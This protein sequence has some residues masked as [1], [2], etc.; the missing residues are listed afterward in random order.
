MPEVPVYVLL[1]GDNAEGDNIGS[2][3]SPTYPQYVG[4]QTGFKIWN[5][6]G[7]AWETYVAGTNSAPESVTNAAHFGPEVSML[8]GLQALNPTQPN[9]YIVKVAVFGSSIASQPSTGNEWN[10]AAQELWTVMNTRVAAAMGNVPIGFTAKL[11]GIFWVH[12]EDDATV[13][14]CEAYE[15]L[16]GILIDR[17]RSTYNEPSIPF[18]IG[19]LHN[20]HPL[21]EPQKSYML[22]VRLAQEA[23]SRKNLNNTLVSTDTLSLKGDQT[24]F[25]VQGTINLGLALVAGLG[26]AGAA[27]SPGD[28]PGAGA[29]PLFILLGDDNAYGHAPLADLPSYLTGT[30]TG[31]K[32]WSPTAGAFQDLVV[33]TN[34][35]SAASSFGPEASLGHALRDMADE[36]IYLVKLGS[37]GSTLAPK[38]GSTNDWCPPSQEIYADLLS[39]LDA[40][41][42]EL[43]TLSIEPRLD[44]IFIV[45][46]QNDALEDTTSSLYEGYLKA[47]VQHLRNDAALRDLVADSTKLPVVIAKSSVKLTA[48]Y[49]ERVR[50]AQ[51]KVYE[52]DPN[53]AAADVDTQSLVPSTVYLDAAAQ[54]FLGK[55]M[56][57]QMIAGLTVQ[58][59]PTF[60]SSIAALKAGMRLS[61]IPENQDVDTMIR[62][63]VLSVRTAFYR[64]L[65]HPRILEIQSWPLTSQP[66]TDKEYLRQVAAT[67]EILMVKRLMLRDLPI[68]FRDSVAPQTDW[69]DVASYRNFGKSEREREIARL[70][71]EIEENLQLLSQSEVAGSESNGIRIADLEQEDTPDLP[72]GSIWSAL[73]R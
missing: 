34:S 40:A 47:L 63:A 13:D 50:A 67:T 56:V 36:T 25:D 30:Q 31:V 64:R 73:R 72:G 5:H 14:R 24:H 32:I 41:L 28:G 7:V 1:G 38:I 39:R 45:L 68:L 62:N 18:V 26:D 10:S 65:L 66:A 20:S 29:S 61:G 58:V 8:S 55:Q 11:K 17:L 37:D 19:R 27:P 44:G 33:G 52:E 12:G 60:V 35:L 53:I 2:S 4:A 49:L 22:T 71:Q 6:L 16:L 43:A 21:A 9:I 3:L 54:V 15:S 48:T 23:V 57:A 46:G 51:Q 69:N 70:E 42:G 59:R